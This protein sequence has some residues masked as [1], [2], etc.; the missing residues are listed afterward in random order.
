[1]NNSASGEANGSESPSPCELPPKT[2]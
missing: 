1:M 2:V